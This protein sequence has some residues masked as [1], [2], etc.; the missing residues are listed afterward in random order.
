MAVS[1]RASHAVVCGEGAGVALRAAPAVWSNLAGVV[2][3]LADKGALRRVLS[4]G[5]AG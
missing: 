5:G 1:P 3:G 2:V 4:K